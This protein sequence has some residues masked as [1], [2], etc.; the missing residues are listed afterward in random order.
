VTCSHDVRQRRCDIR[1]SGPAGHRNDGSRRTGCGGL[2][3]QADIVA[4]GTFVLRGQRQDTGSTA[5][6]T[7]SSG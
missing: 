3:T 2:R 7:G 4:G 5:A 6:V 1:V